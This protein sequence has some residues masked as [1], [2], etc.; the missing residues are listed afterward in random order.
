MPLLHNHLEAVPNIF[1]S[2]SDVEL[3]LH[4]A[5]VQLTVRSCRRAERRKLAIATHLKSTN[6][7]CW[8][9]QLAWLLQNYFMFVLLYTWNGSVTVWATELQQKLQQNLHVAP[10]LSSWRRHCMVRLWFL[11]SQFEGRCVP[12]YSFD[13]K[14]TVHITRCRRNRGHCYKRR[15][16]SGHSIVATMLKPKKEIDQ[17]RN[18]GRGWSARQTAAGTSGGSSHHQPFKLRSSDVHVY[19]VI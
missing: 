11:T 16:V 3:L 4:V 10:P 2:Y 18:E 5:Q 12:V 1:K 15:R 8:V 7:R 9:Q 14:G 19:S 6:S 13:P 17:L